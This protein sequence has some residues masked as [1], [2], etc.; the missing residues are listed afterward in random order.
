MRAPKYIAGFAFLLIGISSMSLD[1]YP[2]KSR[3]VVPAIPRTWDDTQMATLEI[4]LADPVGSPKHASADY[5]YRIPVR[6]IYKSY[7]VYAPG[8]EPPGYLNWLKQQEPVIVWD[9]NGHKPPLQTEADWI[10][11]GEIV[12]DAPIALKGQGDVDATEVRRPEWYEKTGV[13]VTK[14]GVMPFLRYSVRKKGQ[15]ELGAL[16]CATCHTRVMP[17]GTTLKGAQGSFPI[18][19]S[20][21]YG[22]R[23]SVATAKDP[24]QALNDVRANERSLYAM[25]WLRPDP[26]A[27][28]DR[29]SVND[30]AAPRD[31][32]PPGVVARHRSSPLFPVQVPDLI[33]VKDRHYL[34]RTGLQQQRSIDDM[35]RYAALNQGGDDLGNYDGFIPADFP[36][37]K[38]LPDP[39]DPDNIGGRYS[40][41]Q[42]YALALWVYSLQPPPNP[43]KFDALAKHGQK[44]FERESCVMCHTPPLYT[45]NKLTPAEG[46]TVPEDH[47]KKYDILPIS[48]GTDPN[49]TLKTR[50]GTGYYKVPSLKG[51]WYRS[52]FGHSGWCATLEDWFDPRRTRDDYVPT[53][54]KPYG[55]KTYAVKGHPFGLS[56]SEEERKALIAFLKTL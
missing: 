55:M 4:P 37:F 32:I 54:F 51:V 38:K 3:T 14:E 19:R 42:L 28:L 35:M 21:A 1:T 40:D 36:N 5:Y 18:D 47:L 23:T 6:P 25:P 49:L 11:A 43:N 10:K 8:H 27:D 39:T 45:N 15:V 12:F 44:I 22:Y 2:Q 26:L 56:L 50:R 9:D 13:P 41:E 46:F 20:V 52:M 33:G 7:P 29:M 34:D 53:G 17:D 31:V 48:V 16:S 30:I 24:A